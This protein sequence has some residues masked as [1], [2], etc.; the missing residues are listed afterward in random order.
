MALPEL[1]GAFA[2]LAPH[3]L[4]HGVGEQEDALLEERAGVLLGLGAAVVLLGGG[5]DDDE[6]LREYAELGLGRGSDGEDV[7][8][9][10]AR[11]LGGVNRAGGGAGARGDEEEVALRRWPER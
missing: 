10:L 1:L 3:A 9:G 2:A 7:G 8:A 11:D 5:G 6:A 4:E